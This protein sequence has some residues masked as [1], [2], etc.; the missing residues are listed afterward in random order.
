MN[1]RAAARGSISLIALS[2]RRSAREIAV[3]CAWR[4]ESRPNLHTTL[5]FRGQRARAGIR[6]LAEPY[7]DTT[8]DFAEI[9][10]AVLTAHQQREA[11]KRFEDRHWRFVQLHANITVNTKVEC[12]STG[13]MISSVIRSS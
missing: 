8:S 1:E 13:Q 5:A 11:R 9:V 6:S 2:P 3:A 4:G 7:L 10:L 12:T